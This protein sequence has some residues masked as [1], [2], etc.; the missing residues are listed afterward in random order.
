MRRVLSLAVMADHFLLDG[1]D[2]ARAM[3]TLRELVETP[4]LLES[5]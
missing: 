2:V 4:R 3:E 1:S 5:S